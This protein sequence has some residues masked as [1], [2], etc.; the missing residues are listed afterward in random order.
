MRRQG[1]RTRLER[2]ERRELVAPRFLS[3]RVVMALQGAD[4]DTVIGYSGPGERVT[5]M[6]LA[7]EPLGELQARAWAMIGGTSLVTLYGSPRAAEQAPDRG[8]SNKGIAT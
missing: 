5:V 1:F 2:L 6:R 4:T 3:V 7:G 8:W